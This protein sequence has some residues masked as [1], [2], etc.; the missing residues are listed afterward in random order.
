MY[1]SYEGLRQRQSV[2]ISTP[3]LTAAQ[4]AQAQASSDPIVKSLLALIPAA[5]SGTNYL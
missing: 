1:L 2:P 5:N 3:T 4:V